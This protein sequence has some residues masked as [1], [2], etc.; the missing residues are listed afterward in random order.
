MGEGC[1][2]RRLAILGFVE[3]L[4]APANGSLALAV[5]TASRPSQSC[6]SVHGSG[7]R[8]VWN[9]P[10]AGLLA[11]N[12]TR[13]FRGDLSW[14][15][16]WNGVSVADSPMCEKCR[17]GRGQAYGR[18]YES[19]R[20]P[21]CVNLWEKRTAGRT[22]DQGLACGMQA[23]GKDDSGS[24]T[25]RTVVEFWLSG[26]WVLRTWLVVLPLLCRCSNGCRRLA[27]A[28]TFWIGG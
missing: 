15:G 26:V 7:W 10:K 19:L 24:S 21:V 22:V 23:S 1:R 2:P 5:V 27:L 14:G 3:R 4:C 17:I 18:A 11:K 12:S 6:P 20:E 8:P 13:N 25:G 28:P 16:R 9:G